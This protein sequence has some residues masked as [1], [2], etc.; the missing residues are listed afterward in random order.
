MDDKG[1][2]K[3]CDFGISGQL[4]D[5]LAKTVDAGCKPYMAVSSQIWEIKKL[6]TVY[7]MNLSTEGACFLLK[8]F[9]SNRGC[10]LS[11]RTSGHHAINLHKLTLLKELLTGLTLPFLKR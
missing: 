10:G 3:L 2:F 8:I 4:V 7:S 5:S 1:N 11:A 9:V 6:Y